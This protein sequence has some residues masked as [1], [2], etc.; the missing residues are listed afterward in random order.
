MAIENNKPATLN[1]DRPLPASVRW[2]MIRHYCAGAFFIV[3]ALPF[4][5]LG[6]T[7]MLAHRLEFWNL[8]FFLGLLAV[9]GILMIFLAWRSF[10]RAG[11]CTRRVE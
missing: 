7:V 2:E 10:R 5:I 6:I 11:D 1:Y 9:P 8:L 3:L 4:W